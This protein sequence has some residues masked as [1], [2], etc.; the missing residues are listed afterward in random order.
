M[1]WSGPVVKGREQVHSVLGHE[2]CPLSWWAQL[3][4]RG[5]GSYRADWYPSRHPAHARTPSLAASALQSS[6]TF[7]PC[8]TSGSTAGHILPWL[9]PRHYFRIGILGGRVDPMSR[10]HK[11]HPQNAPCCSAG[12]KGPAPLPSAH[13]RNQVS[14]SGGLGRLQLPEAQ[15]RLFSR[16]GG[17]AQLKD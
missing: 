8:T 4:S 16:E 15:G 14:G 7:F 17:G 2:D 10:K 6:F 3:C 5:H 1:R 9:N 11:D 13:A 12:S